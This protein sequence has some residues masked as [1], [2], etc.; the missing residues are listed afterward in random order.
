MPTIVPA[1]PPS[2]LPRLLRNTLVLLTEPGSIGPL[3]GIDIRGWALKPSSMFNTSMSAQS[4]GRTAQSGFGR[5]IR[6]PV[7]WLGSTTVNTSLGNGPPAGVSRL[8]WAVV[9][10]AT[11]GARSSRASKKGRVRRNDSIGVL[12]RGRARLAIGRRKAPKG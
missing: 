7:L 11:T 1:A 8:N 2:V 6:I 10:R 3:N 9:A 4:L 12:R 5:L